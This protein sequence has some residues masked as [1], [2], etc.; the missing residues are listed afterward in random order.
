VIN[1]QGGA[2]VENR[3]VENEKRP[4]LVF[5]QG[6]AVVPLSCRYARVLGRRGIL[7]SWPPKTA[8]RIPENS[9]QLAV[10]LFKIV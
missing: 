5:L 10:S 6:S 3:E 1:V 7:A 2:G 4:F 8:S 9:G